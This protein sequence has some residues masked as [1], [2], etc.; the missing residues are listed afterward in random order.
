MNTDYRL[1]PYIFQDIVSA[2]RAEYDT[3]N[4]KPYFHF[5][6]YLELTKAIAIKDQID[7]EKY[8]LVWL[9]WEAGENTEKWESNKGYEV[10]PRVFICTFTSSDY[11]SSERY[12][13]NFEA[14]LIPIWE[15]LQKKIKKSSFVSN[16]S[17]S[18]QSIEHLLWGESLGF[19]KG[20]NVL[21]DTLD[22]IEV[23]IDSLKINKKC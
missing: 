5:G 17:L 3:N 19:A 21:F 2:V 1:F 11:S 20:Q 14:I 15:I 8:P 9:V 16:I 10:S 23:K 4:L 6:T 13:A 12:S 7:A 22:A 18:F